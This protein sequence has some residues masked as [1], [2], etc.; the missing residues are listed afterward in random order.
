MRAVVERRLAIVLTW[1]EWGY[2]TAFYG[3][4]MVGIGIGLII[5]RLMD[6]RRK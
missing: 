5:T 6:R 1:L 4:V 2:A 3:L